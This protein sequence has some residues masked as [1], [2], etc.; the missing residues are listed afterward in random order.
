MNRINIVCLG[1]RNMEQS[2]RFYKDGLGFQTEETSYN[3]QVIFF[4]AAA[5]L[6]FELYPLDLLAKDIN[7]DNPPTIG[8]GFGGITLQHVVQSKKEVDEVIELARKAGAKIVKEPH[9]A[10][11]GGYTS[12]FLDPNGYY[13]EVSWNPQWKFDQNGMIITAL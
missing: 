6:K 5:G 4:D 12:Y 10:F 2:I 13:W 9:V 1:V 7:E 3:P 11:W 8:D